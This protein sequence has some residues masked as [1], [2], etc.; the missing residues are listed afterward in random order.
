M[1]SFGNPGLGSQTPITFRAT[2]LWN[3]R[4]LKRKDSRRASAR[5]GLR[6]LYSASASVGP[7]VDLDLDHAPVTI[8]RDLEKIVSGPLQ[9]AVKKASKQIKSSTEKL[10]TGTVGVLIG[11]NNGYSYLNADNFELLLVR[12]CQNDSTNIDHVACITVDYH[13]GEADAFVFCTVRC[14]AV[15]GGPAWSEFDGFRVA[16]IDAFNDAMT[17]MMRD[18]MNPRFWDER[19][20][21]VTDI[22]FERNGVAYVR[23]APDVPD[24]RFEE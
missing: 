19:L 22:R 4:S 13:Q 9:T 21:P 3:S 10:G 23:Q 2:L 5:P 24:S 6:S 14:H 16:V 11:V 7:I 20:R 18:Q 12:R 15:R 17:Q 1:W 8:R